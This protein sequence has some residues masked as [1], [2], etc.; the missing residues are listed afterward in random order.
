MLF[1]LYVLKSHAYLKKKRI[2]LHPP[3]LLGPQTKPPTHLP[4]SIHPSIAPKMAKT[5]PFRVQ[6]KSF[7]YVISVKHMHFSVLLI[8]IINF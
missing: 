7:G 1:L 3:P 5:W 2:N 6:D 8:K 4:K